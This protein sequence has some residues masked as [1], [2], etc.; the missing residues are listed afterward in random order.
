MQVVL[1]LAEIPFIPP[2]Q[3]NTSFVEK[4]KMN[5]DHSLIAFTVDIGN[6]ERCTAGLKNM[7]TGQFEP[8]F[9]LEG[10]SQVEFFGK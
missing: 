10:V 8:N 2:K 5:S 3:L 7:T 6:S 9:K 4:L 1:D